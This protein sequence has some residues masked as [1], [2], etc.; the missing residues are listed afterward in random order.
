MSTALTSDLATGQAIAQHADEAFLV[1]LTITHETIVTPFRFVRNRVGITSRGAA[2]LA[3]HFEV[4]LPNDAAEVPQA[5]IAVA[6]VDRRIGQALQKLVTPPSAL[7]EL[8]LASTPDIV[9]RAWDQF[10]LVEATWDAMTVQGVLS[11]IT[12]WDE[13]WPYPRVTPQRFPGLFP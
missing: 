7:I 13:P 4:E 10:S 1:L 8:V 3:S 12:Y 11:R 5:R 2:F 9:E 6:N